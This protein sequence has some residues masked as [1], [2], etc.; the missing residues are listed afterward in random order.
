MTLQQLKYVAA[1]AETCNMAEAS[2]TFLR[3]LIFTICRIVHTENCGTSVT[4]AFLLFANKK[5]V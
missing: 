2:K 5:A 4:I 3:K 1:V